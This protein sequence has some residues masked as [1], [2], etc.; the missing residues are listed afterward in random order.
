MT[1]LAGSGFVISD[2][3]YIVTNYHVIDGA[4]SI[5]VTFY[6]GKEYQA[7]YVG[8]EGT[9]PILDLTKGADNTVE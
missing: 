1:G 3:G 9:L 2:N 4:D 6:D 5:W 8:G 7:T